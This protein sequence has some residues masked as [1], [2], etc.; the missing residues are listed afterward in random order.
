[1]M[2]IPDNSV[3]LGPE[4]EMAPIVLVLHALKRDEAVSVSP[5]TDLARERPI[6]VRASRAVCRLG[7]PRT[8]PEIHD[9]SVLE[10][11]SIARCAKALDRRADVLPEENLSQ[12]R[13]ERANSLAEHPLEWCLGNCQRVPEQ[14][15]AERDRACFP[16]RLSPRDSCCD[17]RSVYAVVIWDAMRAE[18]AAPPRVTLPQAERVAVIRRLSASGQGEHTIAL[19][20]GWT[21]EAVRRVLRGEVRDAA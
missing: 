21:I 10:S 16:H 15:N 12:A 11:F 3:E 4:Q 14:H 8:P 1:M 6:A 5:E 13:L 2:T 18:R 9:C 17:F 20:T 19:A 7:V